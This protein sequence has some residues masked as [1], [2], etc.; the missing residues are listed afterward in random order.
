MLQHEALSLLHSIGVIAVPTLALSFVVSG[1]FVVAGWGRRRE[2]LRRHA[3]GRMTDRFELGQ[4]PF[5]GGVL[6]VVGEARAILRECEGLAARQLAEL[7]CAIQPDLAVRADP[8]AFREILRDLVVN[9]L[10]QAPCGRVLLGAAHASGRVHISVSDD[11]ARVDRE[12]R[13]SRLRPAE[14]LAALQGATMVID[15]RP[16]HGTT[17]VLRMPAAATARRGLKPGPCA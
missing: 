8:R 16:G 14:R 3:P 9:A 13:A 15:A 12:L 6:S 4:T 17:V 1:L 10:N 2:V 7:D 11:G 5:A